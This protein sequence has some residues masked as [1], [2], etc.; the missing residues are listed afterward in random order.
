MAKLFDN[1]DDMSAKRRNVLKTVFPLFALIAVVFG[2]L[3]YYRA[4][5]SALE[6][7]EENAV[8]G[9]HIKGAVKI[10]GYYEVP[11]G[12]RIK[13]LGEVAGGFAETSIWRA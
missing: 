5:E 7:A 12:T 8:V 13:D 2:S 10:S 11:Y 1:M 4:E 6:A 9:V 3:V